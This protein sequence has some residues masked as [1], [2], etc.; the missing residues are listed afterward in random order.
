M[1]YVVRKEIIPLSLGAIRQTGSPVHYLLNLTKNGQK[2]CHVKSLVEWS[3]GGTFLP[4][5]LH[6]SVTNVIENMMTTWE[7]APPQL[8]EFGPLRT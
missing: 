1:K 5:V 7:E 6:I 3:P 2:G 4:R 8:F